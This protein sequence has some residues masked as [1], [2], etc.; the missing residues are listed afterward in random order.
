MPEEVTDDKHYA[1]LNFVCSIVSSLLLR[2]IDAEPSIGLSMN[3]EGSLKPMIQEWLSDHDE[4]PVDVNDVH[5]FALQLAMK[6]VNIP[7]SILTHAIV[8][9]FKMRNKKTSIQH[10]PDFYETTMELIQHVVVKL[11]RVSPYHNKYV[12]D[13][14]RCILYCA[15]C[16]SSFGITGTICKVLTEAP[17]AILYHYGLELPETLPDPDKNLTKEQLLHRRMSLSLPMHTMSQHLNE[18]GADA[19]KTQTSHPRCLFGAED[20]DLSLDDISK[21]R[22]FLH[23]MAEAMRIDAFFSGDEMTCHFNTTAMLFSIFEVGLYG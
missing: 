22:H 5:N 19:T 4:A 23:N 13:S 15:K 10:A 16:K 14:H 1:L 17:F 12:G 18:F 20:I 2:P 21:N 6:G 11:K 9:R 7:L 8:T 3:I